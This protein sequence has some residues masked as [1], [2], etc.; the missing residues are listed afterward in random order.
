[1]EIKAKDS[2]LPG[3]TVLIPFYN[4]RNFLPRLLEGFLQQTVLPAKLV[5]IDN[6]STDDSVEVAKKFLENSPVPYEILH[7]TRKGKA[8]ALEQGCTHIDTEY[9]ICTDADTWFPPHSLELAEKLFKENPDYSCF[10][11]FGINE[12]WPEDEQKRFIDQRFAL[13]ARYKDRCFSG[14]YGHFFRSDAFL[15][16][17]GFSTKIW[18]YALMDHEIIH[19]MLRYG[20]RGYHKDLWCYTSFRRVNRKAIRW[21]FTERFLYR[22]LPSRCMDWFFYKFLWKRFKKRNIAGINLREQPWQKNVG[23]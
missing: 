11:A 9:T 12:E 17:G 18:P 21:N 5:L 20:K 6:D 3:F 13:A 19:R 10:L 2:Y 4:E 16:C 23:H 14:G 15:K 7:E 22:N 1:M 8:N